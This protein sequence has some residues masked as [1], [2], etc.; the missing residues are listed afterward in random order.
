MRRIVVVIAAALLASCVTGT[1][2]LYP[3]QGP[4]M[5][6]SPNVAISV[7]RQGDNLSTTLPSGEMF[8]GSMDWVHGS[9]VT[10]NKTAPQWDLIYG[11]GFFTANVLGTATRT[12]AHLTGNR[13]GTLDLDFLMAPGS[14]TA[15]GIAMDN[16]GNTYKMAM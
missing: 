11:P 1:A 15:K 4:M 7:A 3:V 2:Y 9:D 12:K 16:A 8:K 13:G 14:Q 5:Q 6:S 10:A